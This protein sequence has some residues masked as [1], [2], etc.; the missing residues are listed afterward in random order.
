MAHLPT[1]IDCLTILGACLQVTSIYAEESINYKIEIEG[2]L[3]SFW[4][5]GLIDRH[6]DFFPSFPMRTKRFDKLS[7]Q[8]EKE[9]TIKWSTV[10]SIS[11]MVLCPFLGNCSIVFVSFL[12]NLEITTSVTFVVA[13]F[14]FKGFSPIGDS[15]CTF[16]D[17]GVLVKNSHLSHLKTFTLECTKV[18]LVRLLFWE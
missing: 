1:Y 9:Y 15:L 4:W 13:F 5:N 2:G 6:F 18:C 3:H 7:G 12:V 14:T 10:M 16:R 17:D 11:N 8:E